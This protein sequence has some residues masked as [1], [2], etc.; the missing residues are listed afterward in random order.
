MR[1]CMWAQPMTTY[2]LSWLSLHTGC[3]YP[4]P[5]GMA[6][7]SAY[8]APFAHDT[9]FFPA[10]GRA[11]LILRLCL[12]GTLLHAALDSRGPRAWQS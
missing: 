12:C 2:C 6:Y 3:P 1:S 4:R 7:V 8:V 10:P 9:L 11:L 5:Q